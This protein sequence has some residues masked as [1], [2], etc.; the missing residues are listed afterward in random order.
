[1][2]LDLTTKGQWAKHE[3]QYGFA[4]GQGI[5]LLYERGVGITNMA[6]RAPSG[7]GVS[8]GGIQLGFGN[9]NGNGK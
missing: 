9:S 2:W 3:R 8:L 1:M 7:A 4:Y 6:L 5:P